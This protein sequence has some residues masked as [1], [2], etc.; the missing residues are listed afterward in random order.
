MGLAVPVMRPSW[1]LGQQLSDAM[2]NNHAKSW[3]GL[4]GSK[5]EE[6]RSWGGMSVAPT[7]LGAALL[8]L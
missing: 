2:S 6:D 7:S 5:D 3:L 1:H 4:Y 8:L